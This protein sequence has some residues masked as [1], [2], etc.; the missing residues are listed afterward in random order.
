MTNVTVTE[1]A[2]FIPEIWAAS[3]LGYLKKN[4]VMARLVNRNFESQFQ[5]VGDIINV[6]RRGT[7]SVND[8]AANTG[9][10]LQTPTAD[11]IPL[12][13]NKHKEVSFL[14]E[15]IAKAQAN[16][17]GIAGY[18]EDGIAKIA[19][20][21]DT[22]IL[23]LYSGFSTT[24]IDA[25]GGPSDLAGVGV[26]SATVIEANRL[27]NVAKAPTSPRYIVWHPSAEAEI[28]DKEKFTSSDFGDPGTA[29]RDAVVGRK[30]GFTHL[31]SQNVPTTGGECK[32]LAFHPDAIMMA[33]RPLP[34]PPEGTG[35][36][37][38]TMSEDGFGVR[39]LYGYNMQYLGLQVTI[40][41]LY[42]VA[43]MRDAFGIVIRST[44]Y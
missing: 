36:R 26:R 27:L 12:T 30:F 9:V 18:I 6:P 34:P 39:I 16:Q 33:F 4:T 2:G 17:D 31:M 13:L 22:D 41:V 8:K 42:G 23:A 40:D 1:Y 29:V 14:V 10:T 3:A 25:T 5:G 43:E 37:A 24:P 15:D 20:A 19:E 28:L 7:L 38:V 21:V 35:A 44:D 32:N 11:T